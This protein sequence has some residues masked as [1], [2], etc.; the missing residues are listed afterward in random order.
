VHAA[1]DQDHGRYRL[2]QRGPFDRS[3]RDVLTMNQH[4]IGM[5]TVTRVPFWADGN[6]TE[7]RSIG[8]S[9]RS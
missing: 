5:G 3:L 7:R 4:V 2:Y 8:G 6:G 9:C 1:R